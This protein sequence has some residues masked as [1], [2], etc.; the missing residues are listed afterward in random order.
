M[1]KR[2]IPGIEGVAPRRTSRLTKLAAAAVASAALLL[3]ATGCSSFSETHYF[4]SEGEPANYFRLRVRGQT[5]LGSARYLSGYFDEEAVNAY[6]NETA[7]PDKARFAA[8][9][10]STDAE[11]DEGESGAGT[12]SDKELARVRPLGAAPGD[13][14]ILVMLLSS[15]SDEIAEQIG[16]FAENRQIAA[17]L[18]ALLTRGQVG[19]QRQVARKLASEQT[20]AGTM[21]ALGDAMVEQLTA[22]AL[23]FVNRVAGELGHTGSF[24][25]LAAAKKWLDE[26]R[27][28]LNLE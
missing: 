8:T 23:K 11:A 10:P 15:N 1:S 22:A 21:V 4:K 20:R 9:K 7:Q 16:A 19:D 24:A 13:D 3:P 2:Q 12:S 28:R 17:T 5:G 25:D 14:R 26:N 18:G 27:G 6:F